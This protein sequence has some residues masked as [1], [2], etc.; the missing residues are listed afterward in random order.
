MVTSSRAQPLGVVGD[1]HG[2]GDRTRGHLR[3]GSAGAV[4]C[5]RP[6]GPSART[7]SPWR[8]AVR[9]RRTRPSSSTT[10][11][12]STKESPSP[13]FSSG[14]G[15][16]GPIEGDHGVPELLGRLSRLDDGPHD[17]QRAL[18][19]EERADRVTQFLLIAREFELHRCPLPDA[20]PSGRARTAASVPDARV[21]LRATL[22]AQGLLG[23]KPM[24]ASGGGRRP[25]AS[26]PGRRQR[27]G[28]G[29]ECADG[30][31]GPATA[32]SARAR[33]ARGSLAYTLRCASSS[34]AEQRTLNP[35]VSG[36]NPEGRTLKFSPKST[37]GFTEVGEV[38]GRQPCG[39]YRL[40]VWPCRCAGSCVSPRELR[41]VPVSALVAP[42][43][44]A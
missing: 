15:E 35:Q 19:L 37:S 42:S 17:G 10:T 38:A 7:G 13:P 6:R 11:A 8:G 21:S 9:A 30:R 18:L 22:S 25:V 16:C 44:G 20:A 3:R 43:L 12:V 41:V 31:N 2:A 24:A 23:S 33:G 28:S 27:G 14:H 1:G 36:S 5:R 32:E 39:C 4:R 40:A 29:L 34:T 26:G